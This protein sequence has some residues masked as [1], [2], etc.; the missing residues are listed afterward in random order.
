MTSFTFITANDIHISDTGPR[1]RIDDF[2]ETML[3]KINQMRV[4]CQKLSADAALIAGDLYNLKNP[5]RNSHHLNQNLIKIFKG[6]PCPIYM[7]PGN[8]DLTANNLES[9]EKQPL[10]VLFEDG[11]LINLKEETLE[12]EGMKISLV[13]VPYT[14]HLDLTKLSF[15][16]KKDFA[17]QICLMHIYASKKPGML[18]KE[19]LYG[20]DELA[21]LS[22]DVFVI[23]H[24][25]ADQGVEK[26]K[27]KYFLNIGSM[28]RGTLSEDSIDHHPKI[29]FIRVTK[30][31]DQLSMVV[32]SIKLRIKPAEEIFDLQKREEERQESKEIENFVET[33]LSESTSDTLDLS[34]DI[35]GIVSEMK[36]AREVQNKV[37]HFIQEA[38]A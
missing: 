4:A 32:D 26:L 38:A 9:L 27:D 24:Y 2:K 28:S 11:T 19:R 29:G 6:F 10:G 16:D 22:P 5:T 1:S 12:K 30:E 25:H 36:I 34:Q 37:M 21:V 20:Y 31:E 35:K 33:L 3:D 8:H 7:I 17:A 23:G 14:E 18:Y 15:P 13:G